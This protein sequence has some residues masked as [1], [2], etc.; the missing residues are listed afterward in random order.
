MEIK[1]LN[2]QNKSIMKKQIK[3]FALFLLSLPL[4]TACE[5]D[6]DSNP[7][8]N[9]PESF[10]LNTPANAATQVYDLKNIQAIELTCEQPDYG[11]QPMAT[12]YQIQVSLGETFS[13][14]DEEA[15]TKANYRT[16]S[17]TPYS[18]TMEV[19]ATE[20]A[21]LIGELWTSD[22]PFPTTPIPVYIRLRAHISNSER[23]V[24]H[25]NVI[26][27][28]KVLGYKAEAPVA[29]PEEMYIIGDM[30][31]DGW[32]TWKPLYPT[33]QKPGTF[34]RMVYFD[35]ATDGGNNFK[36]GP[37]K[38]NWGTALAFGKEH[39]TAGKGAAEITGSDDGSGG[40]NFHVGKPGWYVVAI[41]AEISGKNIKY[42]I[43]L[44]E[45]K[46]YLIGE[47]VGSWDTGEA[48]QFTLP[49]KDGPFVSKPCT[50][51]GALRMS[52]AVP[53]IGDWW[54]CEF[55]LDKATAGTIIYR[56]MYEYENGVKVAD[57]LYGDYNVG[58]TGEP[59]KQVYL[60][61]TAGTGELK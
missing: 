35:G 52:M 45:P 2:Q 48:T 54:R 20:L 11:G 1:Q 13:E 46:V 59:G 38:G 5:T 16:L 17:I 14:A 27:L 31:G 51:G 55:T 21:L 41:T 60:D 40:F 10:V 53:G 44:G 7:I 49:A 9:E 50:A 23:G 57:S 37:D 56:G 29:L 12:T 4:F 36:F 26:T 61:F 32:A 34:F 28:A 18:T 47:S 25:S 42:T 3:S 33:S 6:T 43:Q 24:C 15:G 8:L 39:V 58:I 30:N 22:E 19:D